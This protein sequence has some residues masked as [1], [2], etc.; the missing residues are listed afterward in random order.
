MTSNTVHGSVIEVRAHVASSTT[1][2]C[3]LP[4]EWEHRVQVVEVGHN[5]FSIMAAGAVRS[6]FNHVLVYKIRIVTSMALLARAAC[7]PE[8]GRGYMASTAAHR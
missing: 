4:I 6:E 7:E 5:I 8:F 3:M 2:F 1:C